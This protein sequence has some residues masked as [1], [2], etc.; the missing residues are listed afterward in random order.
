MS[1]NVP[2]DMCAQR[3]FRSDCAVW[4][5]SLLGA[6]W[7]GNHAKCFFFFFFFFCFFFFIRTTKN[8]IS[9]R[10]C[11]GWANFG[12][13]YAHISEGTYSHIAAWKHAYSNILKI[14]QLKKENFQIKKS[15]VF[16]II[17]KNIECEYSLEPPRRGGSKPTIYVFEQK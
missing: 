11:V 8:L 9:L 10:G 7:T 1:E 12:L 6:F 4:S 5:E 16:H 13:S 17:A 2:S 3:R 15:D 14:L